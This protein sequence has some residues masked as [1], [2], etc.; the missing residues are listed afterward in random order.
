MKTLLLTGGSGLLA[1]N[2]ARAMAA[3][4]SIHLTLHGRLIALPGTVS[5]R[6]DLASP[7]TFGQLLDVVGPDLVV[8]T[9][10]LTDVERCEREPE[11]A[12]FANVRIP[13]NVA[14]CCADRGI[15]LVHVSTDHLFSGTTPMLPE[16]AVV[17]P[18]NTYART[19]AEGETEVLAASPAALIVRTNFYGWGPSYRCSFSD[20]IIGALRRREETVLFE[21]VYFTPILADALAETVHDLVALDASGIYHVVGDKRLSKHEFGMRIAEVFALDSGLIRAGRLASTDGLTVRPFEMSLSNFKARN[22]LGREIGGV[23]A[24]LRRLAA[25]ESDPHVKEVQAL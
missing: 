25:I 11:T 3:E 13:A 24:H 18:L 19:K 21:D 20:R 4:W 2:W 8:H 1:L 12:W 10:G 7:D 6:A 14:A 9:A 5:H 15:G 17:T 22:L 23:D 16:D